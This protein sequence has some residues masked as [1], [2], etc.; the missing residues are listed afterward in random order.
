MP[1][2]WCKSNGVTS[3][4]A[5]LR[6][7]RWQFPSGGA[8]RDAL[9]DDRHGPLPALLLALTVLAGVVD[10]VS[11]AG[12]DHVFVAAQTGNLVL[13]GLGIAGLGGFSVAASAISLV[14]FL[15]GAL[16]GT[17]ICRRSG[18][19]RGRALRN[20]T[21]F[22]AV[23][24]VPA[25]L[26]ALLA[27]DTFDD[28]ARI[29]ITILLAI[30]MGSQL[31]LIRYLKVPDLMTTVMTL[32]MTGAITD[33]VSGPRDLVLIRRGLALAAFA[34]G[35]IAGGLLIRFVSAGAALALGLA[36]IVAAGLA[37]HR[38]SRSPA[39]WAAPR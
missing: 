17:R 35:V 5:A 21:V 28:G 25:T 11:I 33:H 12:L 38:V 20:V 6:G 15:A 22:K 1:S 23:L 13:I 34:A 4:Q 2:D 29:V 37:A 26:V 19:H 39:P 9:I 30:S 31:A 7:R 18:D 8:L 14:S 36:I 10:A 27:G 3:E 32:T 16:A 24:A